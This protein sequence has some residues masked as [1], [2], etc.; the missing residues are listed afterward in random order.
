MANWNFFLKNLNH[1]NTTFLRWKLIQKSFHPNLGLIHTR[2]F[3]TQYFDK[4]KEDI[5]MKRYF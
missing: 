2:H 1:L 4:K 5:E 3:G